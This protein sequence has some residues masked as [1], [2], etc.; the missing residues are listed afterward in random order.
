MTIPRFHRKLTSDPL[1]KPV[2]KISTQSKEFIDA[3]NDNHSMRDKLFNFLL[4]QITPT[5][6]T[7]NMASENSPAE[8]LGIKISHHIVDYQ[9]ILRDINDDYDEFTS[10]KQGYLKE[11][12]TL[13]CEIWQQYKQYFSML[14]F[15]T[16]DN[17]FILSDTFQLNQRSILRFHQEIMFLRDKV[18]CQRL[19]ISSIEAFEPSNL[20]LQSPPLVVSTAEQVKALSKMWENTLD[21][22][23]S[24]SM[25]DYVPHSRKFFDYRNVLSQNDK[26]NIYKIVELLYQIND[27]F[28]VRRLF[29]CPIGE[30][31][32]A[33]QE[34][35][36]YTLQNALKVKP[37]SDY[38]ECISRHDQS[39][40]AT[41]KIILKKFEVSS[42]CLRKVF[43]SLQQLVNEQQNLFKEVANVNMIEVNAILL[44]GMKNPNKNTKKV[45]SDLLKKQPLHVRA[46]MLTH[47]SIYEPRNTIALYRLIV[48]KPQIR[49]FGSKYVYEDEIVKEF[50]SSSAAYCYNPIKALLNYT[51]F[52]IQLQ[53][54]EDRNRAFQF[55]SHLS[56]EL[57]KTA[58]NEMKK[59]INGFTSSLDAVVSLIQSKDVDPIRLT[60]LSKIKDLLIQKS[61]QLDRMSK[62]TNGL[63]MGNVVATECAEALTK[64]IEDTKKGIAPK[65]Q[66]PVQKMEIVIESDLPALITQF[67]K[68]F[69]DK[70]AG[71]ESKEYQTAFNRLFTAKDLLAKHFGVDPL[72]LFAMIDYCIDMF[73][74][75]NEEPRHSQTLIS[76]NDDSDLVTFDPKVCVYAPSEKLI[77][78][79]QSIAM[80]TDQLCQV[81]EKIV[82]K[83]NQ[84]MPVAARSNDLVPEDNVDVQSLIKCS[85]E[86]V[87]NISSQ[88]SSRSLIS[89]FCFHLL[90]CGGQISHVDKQY[91]LSITQK[92]VNLHLEAMFSKLHASDNAAH[93]T[94]NDYVT[95]IKNTY[96]RYR[97]KYA[98]AKAG[99][100]ICL[101]TDKYNQPYFNIKNTYSAKEVIQR[102][103]EID[104]QVDD[105]MTIYKDE[106]AKCLKSKPILNPLNDLI[107]VIHQLK[108]KKNATKDT[109]LAFAGVSIRELFARLSDDE[110]SAVLQA[111]LK[112][113]VPENPLWLLLG[114]IQGDQR[115]ISHLFPAYAVA[116]SI[117]IK[118][119]I[120]HSKDRVRD[121]IAYLNI[122][123]GT[124]WDYRAA[125][126]TALDGVCTNDA[127]IKEV[128]NHIR[129]LFDTVLSFKLT[130]DASK[131]DEINLRYTR[132]IFPTNQDGY[133]K[134]IQSIYAEITRIRELPNITAIDENMAAIVR[135][136]R[137][138]LAE[139][140]SIIKNHELIEDQPSQKLLLPSVCVDMM[141]AER[142]SGD[143]KL[144]LLQRF[145]ELESKK[146]EPRTKL[147]LNQVDKNSHSVLWHTVTAKQK[148]NKNHFV[149]DFDVLERMISYGAMLTRAEVN[150]G[151]VL[152]TLF[153]RI[154][155]SNRIQ[156]LQGICILNSMH[157]S[158]KDI[159][160]SSS[161]EL[162]Y[163]CI[164]Y[165]YFKL[166]Y[167][168]FQEQLK[169]LGN[170]SI[171]REM[172]TLQSKM[173]H[174][175]ESFVRYI[176]NAFSTK[177]ANKSR[178]S[179][180]L[181]TVTEINELLASLQT[182]KRNAI[183]ANQGKQ[184]TA[185]GKQIVFQESSENISSRD[186]T[187]DATNKQISFASSCILLA[188]YTE[189]EELNNQFNLISHQPEPNKVI[190]KKEE[191]TYTKSSDKPQQVLSHLEN[192][193]RLIDAV[194]PE[195]F[196]VKQ[197][198][199][200]LATLTTDEKK[201][202]S[203]DLMLAPREQNPIFKL[204][205]R[206]HKER[207]MLLLAY[208]AYSY[209][210]TQITA[211]INELAK[212][213][214][215]IQDYFIKLFEILNENACKHWSTTII[216]KPENLVQGLPLDV[217]NSTI[218]VDII[219][220]EYTLRTIE[221]S[222]LD[223]LE[224]YREYYPDL[225]HYLGLC[226]ESQVWK[227][228]NEMKSAQLCTRQL[229]A[230]T[231][232]VDTSV[233]NTRVTK[234]ATV[235]QG[236]KDLISEIISVRHL[237]DGH[238][239][240][241]YANI[242]RNLDVLNENIKHIIDVKNNIEKEVAKDVDYARRDIVLKIVYNSVNEKG[243][244]LLLRLLSVR[245]AKND[246]AK[247]I[248]HK[249]LPMTNI[250]D[251]LS[252]GARFTP[253][254]LQ[255]PFK[256]FDL[257]RSYC[258]AHLEEDIKLRSF[259]WVDLKEYI[260]IID[261]IMSFYSDESLNLAP[262]IK[263]EAKHYAETLRRYMTATYYAHWVRGYVSNKDENLL[264]V[265]DNLERLQ[266]D[267]G[268][269]I[270]KTTS[271]VV[272]DYQ[273]YDTYFNAFESEVFWKVL[274]DKRDKINAIL[275]AYAKDTLFMD[276][277]KWQEVRELKQNISHL[278]GMDLGD[279][280]CTEIPSLDTLLANRN[281]SMDTTYD[282]RL[283]NLSIIDKDLTTILG[284]ARNAQTRL[285]KEHEKFSKAQ[286]QE[287]VNAD[288]ALQLRT[289]TLDAMIEEVKKLKP[290]EHQA[291]WDKMLDANGKHKDQLTWIVDGLSSN[292]VSLN[293]FLRIMQEKTKKGFFGGS[294][295]Y[296][297]KPNDVL[298]AV[299]CLIGN[300]QST[301]MNFMLFYHKIVG[302]IPLEQYSDLYQYE[303]N[304]LSA[305]TSCQP[306]VAKSTIEFIQ[307]LVQSYRLKQMSTNLKKYYK[308]Y[309][310]PG[311][312]RVAKK[313]FSKRFDGFIIKISNKNNTPEDMKS[314][315]AEQH[316]LSQ[317]LTDITETYARLLS[318]ANEFQQIENIHDI[319]AKAG[320]NNLQTE[321]I[322][323]RL[324]SIKLMSS[325]VIKEFI[326]SERHKSTGHSLLYVYLTAAND[327]FDREDFYYSLQSVMEMVA[328][329]A[330]LSPKDIE[331][332]ALTNIFR[333]LEKRL[334]HSFDDLKNCRDQCA[335]QTEQFVFTINSV[336]HFIEDVILKYARSEDIKRIKEKQSELW[337][338]A[339]YHAFQNRCDQ[340]EKLIK[341]NA[342][343]GQI[344]EHVTQCLKNIT[345]N[346]TQYSAKRNSQYSLAALKNLCQ[347]KCNIIN[348]IIAKLRNFKRDNP[349][350]QIDDALALIQTIT[351]SR[352]AAMG[353]LDDK[354]ALPTL[355]A[356]FNTDL[357]V[358]DW[359]EFNA[360]VSD[361]LPLA[362][363]VSKNIDTAQQNINEQKKR[364]EDERLQKEMSQ[365]Q[366]DAYNAAQSTFT[367]KLTQ[368]NESINAL[369]QLL[370]KPSQNEQAQHL[371]ILQSEMTKQPIQDY[372]SSYNTMRVQ[373]GLK[374][375]GQATG[376]RGLFSKKTEQSPL[377]TP[378][379]VNAA[380]TTKVLEQQTV[381]ME[382][383]V[384]VFATIKTALLK[385]QELYAT[386]NTSVNA[387]NQQ[388]SACMSLK[389]KSHFAAP[390][391]TFEANL[392]QAQQ[393]GLY[394]KGITI[395][396]EK[397]T[398]SVVID[399]AVLDADLTGQ[400]EEIQQATQKLQNAATKFN[401]QYQAKLQKE[402][403]DLQ[404]SVNALGEKVASLLP[405]IYDLTQLKELVHDVGTDGKVIASNSLGYDEIETAKKWII[406]ALRE[407][408]EKQ[409]EKLSIEEQVANLQTQLSETQT[410]HQQALTNAQ[411]VYEKL[412]AYEKKPFATLLAQAKD[413]KTKEIKSTV[414]SLKT[415]LKRVQ[416]EI[417]AITKAHTEIT[418]LL[419]QKE[420]MQSEIATKRK[421]YD[422][423]NV[424]LG[425][426][427]EDTAYQWQAIASQR[428]TVVIDSITVNDDDSLTQLQQKNVNVIKA[429]EESQKF[430][431]HVES[432]QEIWVATRDN[433]VKISKQ[434]DDY[435]ESINN[436]STYALLSDATTKHIVTVRKLK[437]D[438]KELKKSLPK[439]ADKLRILQTITQQYEVLLA[440]LIALYGKNVKDTLVGGAVAA[441]IAQHGEILAKFVTLEN[442]IAIINQDNNDLLEKNKF[443]Q[444][445][446]DDEEFKSKP[447][448]A[449]MRDASIDMLRENFALLTRYKAKLERDRGTYDEAITAKQSIDDRIVTLKQQ[450]NDQLASCETAIQTLTGSSIK[451]HTLQESTKAQKQQLANQIQI[452]R[453]NY[454]V[455]ASAENASEGSVSLP[456][457]AERQALSGSPQEQCDALSNALKVVSALKLDQGVASYIDHAHNDGV[458]YQALLDQQQ[459]L[460]TQIDNKS[461]KTS[462]AVTTD[463]SKDQPVAKSFE[464]LKR[465]VEVLQDK[466]NKIAKDNAK[467]AD[468]AKKQTE[469]NGL[470]EVVE[471]E[472]HGIADTPELKALSIDDAIKGFS[473]RLN[474]I[475]TPD[476]TM[477]NI[478]G[479]MTSVERLQSDVDTY[480]ETKITEYQSLSRQFN[481]DKTKIK[482]LI[483]SLNDLYSKIQSFEEDLPILDNELIGSLKDIYHSYDQLSEQLNGSYSGKS[484]EE[485]CAQALTN[486]TNITAV[487]ER[488]SG[489]KTQI[490]EKKKQ[491]DILLEDIKGT[492]VT[493][494]AMKDK[495]PTT[496]V[497]AQIPNQ[498]PDLTKKSFKTLT[499]ILEMILQENVKFSE[500]LETLQPKEPVASEPNDDNASVQGINVQASGDLAVHKPARKPARA[501][502]R[503]TVEQAKKPVQVDPPVQ[504]RLFAPAN[505]VANQSY[506][507]AYTLAYQDFCSSLIQTYANAINEFST[508]ADTLQNS[509]CLTSKQQAAIA[510][511]S[512][513]LNQEL[514]SIRQDASQQSKKYLIKDEYD[515]K[516]NSIKTNFTTAVTTA[517]NAIKL[518]EKKGVGFVVG[519]KRFWFSLKN[520]FSSKS[521]DPLVALAKLDG[522]QQRL[523]DPL[524]HG[525]DIDARVRDA[526][527]T[528]MFQPAPTKAKVSERPSVP[529]N[530]TEI[531][532]TQ[533]T[534]VPNQETLKQELHQLQ[535]Q[536]KTLEVAVAS[537]QIMDFN[538][539]VSQGAQKAREKAYGD[540]HAITWQFGTAAMESQIKALK[541]KIQAIEAQLPPAVKQPAKNNRP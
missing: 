12:T 268:K 203:D 431:R 229:G 108:L 526:Q 20:E 352:M 477:E 273:S 11:Q 531:T 256:V 345:D 350:I 81:Q 9:S 176:E 540:N 298:P 346:L 323:A 341:S 24:M 37:C 93:L 278:L 462:D 58:D 248:D 439:S 144:A 184:T 498:L 326:L 69:R 335:K 373:L 132:P 423:L 57:Q 100:L 393:F 102:R 482:D 195:K 528:Y 255:E 364:L 475:K 174:A 181:P 502:V 270:G 6:T 94:E 149:F 103:K 285:A 422:D 204:L 107:Q 56:L 206:K 13:L 113:R 257:V 148:S 21:Y 133:L 517:S 465:D 414:T 321:K 500:H 415:E 469:L 239:L 405:E 442:E 356:D 349:S 70:C 46:S 129:D 275:Q 245:Q 416:D 429:Y 435:N 329:G 460:T 66:V 125:S 299:I 381:A 479:K 22:T 488:F 334:A 305:I 368:V 114:P 484:L 192:V 302:T 503:K 355:F 491:R 449:Q 161:H 130:L 363:R 139:L 215:N 208:D 443:L 514:R 150:D 14:S 452:L 539:Q 332:Y 396:L 377:P 64:I 533:T 472:I 105:L 320:P 155:S 527:R 234:R 33:P 374:V 140:K 205:T 471:T 389:S 51:L 252:K 196:D 28:N 300:D 297:F 18:M 372:K 263:G 276:K 71:K 170:G 280:L 127:G 283:S 160:D 309:D 281:A 481:D 311:V 258:A 496:M 34:Q 432:Q 505:E 186:M 538:A 73:L 147:Y 494:M 529:K 137:E 457:S 134:I 284:F 247:T 10:K 468:H 478:D 253:I 16:K 521:S 369:N 348:D 524:M 25:S 426:L 220:A 277:E 453:Q 224:K 262:A 122:L 499:A 264:T 516:I 294:E 379:V 19:N 182:I 485:Q 427:Q 123:Q 401:E 287:K 519:L 185:N 395:K 403:L 433:Y 324:N 397:N 447:T 434:C 351:E 62:E 251:F 306:A 291:A 76:S 419:T 222:H 333:V 313:D 382:T 470:I 461:E 238:Q 366:L 456:L 430:I 54:N 86:Y 357:T 458:A 88:T 266:Q 210:Y 143:K 212:I 8:T 193:N 207:L 473:D 269:K 301:L 188:R 233:Q 371:V 386:L 115:E 466:L 101:T 110:K 361:M 156:C 312:V 154:N 84:V 96:T 522:Q 119:S 463:T 445:V 304:I 290:S 391:K 40:R 89:Q 383:C 145:R 60:L 172:E 1:N 347:L 515:Q 223:E 59:S 537:K 221:K 230:S 265:K 412:S 510:T 165:F 390:L 421:A 52:A 464:E 218:L 202:L 400:I 343:N 495:V 200:Y 153:Q 289:K 42:E 380:T 136:Y 90:K 392:S 61:Q 407:V 47:S 87:T 459:A 183:E 293:I 274:Q 404:V 504:P 318:T 97:E 296:V 118:F 241:N 201:N 486:I 535:S 53:D 428:P 440:G 179:I 98:D 424:R 436:E 303:Q 48:D 344:P 142:E 29:S 7:Y 120:E 483:K 362:Y 227:T 231:V 79:P 121:A 43:E 340:D 49:F 513:A 406:N 370:L 437:D 225:S 493:Y 467:Q 444:R 438:I 17:R 5:A 167:D 295:T 378:I 168:V 338:S 325:P 74:F 413:G 15:S 226:K 249:C 240:W 228:L 190:S 272:G 520:L 409:Q 367:D 214:D 267:L 455:V 36:W 402:R 3:F 216:S 317:E 492:F 446:A 385:Q 67:T 308:Q 146:S 82:S 411:A 41:Y 131:I 177:G 375:E 68:T 518:D 175:N 261:K 399:G 209:N 282:V 32:L 354:D 65:V 315:L 169:R 243:Q 138:S 508:V 480:K 474:R 359:L 536:L 23:S 425:Q 501:P 78:S 451:D 336:N 4:G 328:L 420:E 490:I 489:F 316:S 95:C 83:R 250:S 189:D 314:L 376:L 187:L 454:S 77:I 163:V 199:D 128:Y 523:F 198:A 418:A 337:Y 292:D 339:Y 310:V 497:V 55:I 237:V 91:I 30:S 44:D 394:R 286:Q 99:C 151:I 530:Q 271:V 360:T 246:A 448:S 388:L 219:F 387:Y 180:T 358:N 112:G 27:T 279:V 126:V 259:E 63:S 511:L 116:C 194:A 2:E 487:I 106:K 242:N 45:V 80:L 173:S 111:T 117:I 365:Q 410:A 512:Q 235:E 288:K 72:I 50:L 158:Y 191:K 244:S 254:E 135:K 525:I 307:L 92:L 260:G 534:A 162:L 124:I 384:E 213:S 31:I 197:L 331:S 157:T 417:D 152:A 236:V 353:S 507:N 211:V 217:E 441:E 26:F 319:L 104:S 166:I 408:A 506:G 159:P 327:P 38:F 322:K 342:K 541:E 35:D 509:G 450:L 75:I 109:L 178:Y 171:R 164:N 398:L 85:D 532:K 476:C 232:Y 39:N 330:K 141:Y